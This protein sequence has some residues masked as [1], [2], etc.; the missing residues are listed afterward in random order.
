[1]KFKTLSA[2]CLAA[3]TVLATSSAM[4]WESEDGAHSVTANVLL[5]S[6]YIFRGAS[7]T[8]NNPTIQGGLDYGHASGL[9]VGAWASNVDFGNGET[10]DEDEAKSEFN[11]YGGFASEIGET[12]IGY[13][14]GAIRYYYPGLGGSADFNEIYGS[15]SY[16]FFTFGIAHTGNVFNGGEDATY[17]NIAFEYGLPY[18]V[19]FMAHIGYQDFDNEDQDGPSYNDYLIGVSKTMFDLDFALTWTDTD[20]DGEDFA[21]DKD[22]VDNIFTVSVSKSF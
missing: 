8:D 11:L 9:Y 7:Q 21:G 12:G 17:Y 19:T 16:S 15:L 1:M 22:L 2:M 20:S 10:A 3:T 5:G 4:A 14:I 18:D 6:D 13:D